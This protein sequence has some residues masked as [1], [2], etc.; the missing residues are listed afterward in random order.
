MF[1]TAL[2]RTLL[3]RSI[4][5]F[6]FSAVTDEE[7]AEVPEYKAE[8]EL[9]LYVHIPF[10]RAL[11]SFCPY[12]KQVYDQQLAL[13]YEKAL[14]GEIELVSR[15]LKNTNGI[16]E[17]K[18]VSSLYFGGGSPALMASSIGRIIEAL[19]KAFIITQGIGVELHPS[20]ITKELLTTLRNS[21][22]T[23]ISIGIQSFDKNCL[24][25]LGRKESSYDELFSDVRSAGFDVV[26]VDLIFAI[27]GQ[28]TEIS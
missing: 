22:V 5:P 3:T 19:K 8:K 14:L 17:K 25:A 23:M 21:S 24:A 20:D 2:L 12:C 4:K 7:A 11:C 6:I 16:I 9:G 15:Q 26:D 10:C 18:K 13:K 27:P 28:T 1:L